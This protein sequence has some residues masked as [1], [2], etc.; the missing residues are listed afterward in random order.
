MS[1]KGNYPLAYNFQRSE[2]A[3][4][5]L[6]LQLHGYGSHENDLYAM[7]DGLPAALHILS[8]RAPLNLGMGGF[9]WYEI[10]FNQPGAKM[11]NLEQAR[12]SLGLIRTFLKRFREAEDLVESEV[13][14]MGFSQGCILSYALALQEPHNFS[15]VLALSGYVLKEL[16]PEQYQPAQIQHLDFFVSHG[17][18][19]PII[20]V[21]A[22]RQSVA[23]LEKLQIS[24][25]YQEYPVGHGV[26]PENFRD[27][28]KWLQQRLAEG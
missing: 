3:K 20:P 7:R 16:V 6:L 27:L 11:N 2:E 15:K 25:R 5:P 4:A 17:S 23:M 8:L 24:H 28:Q 22:A 21:Q 10:D 9:A 13:W 19:D 18:E 26:A 14:L 12:E 1:E